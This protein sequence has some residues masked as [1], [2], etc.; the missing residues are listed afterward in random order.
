MLALKPIKFTYMEIK[1]FESSF[2]PYE[3]LK[4]LGMLLT[5]HPTLALTPPLVMCSAAAISGVTLLSCER[6]SQS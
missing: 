5:S 2:S 3:D 4:I 6:M 1:I